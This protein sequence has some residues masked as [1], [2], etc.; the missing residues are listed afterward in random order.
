MSDLKTCPKCG[1]ESG[2]GVDAASTPGMIEAWAR[3][4]TGE[5]DIGCGFEVDG[6]LRFVPGDSLEKQID[7]LT[8][9][10]EKQWNGIERNE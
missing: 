6:W 2:I 10:I 1:K 5:D 3:C 7:F 4:G 9:K 8:D